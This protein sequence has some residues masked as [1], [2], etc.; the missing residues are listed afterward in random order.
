MSEILLSSLDQAFSSLCIESLSPRR[1]EVSANR[2][3]ELRNKLSSSIQFRGVTVGTLP[4]LEDDN[5]IYIEDPA[6]RQKYGENNN[7]YREFRVYNGLLQI[8]Y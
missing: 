7:T 4:C 1:I 5:L 6:L 3:A 2:L 8:T